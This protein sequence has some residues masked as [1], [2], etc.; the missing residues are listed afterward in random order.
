MCLTLQDWANI[1]V[2]V[3]AVF[4]VFALFIAIKQIFEAK[5]LRKIQMIRELIN[6]IGDEEIKKIRNWVIYDMPEPNQE[7]PLRGLTLKDIDNA[8]KL[9]VAYDRICFMI[10]ESKYDIFKKFHKDDVKIIWD[11]LENLIKYTQKKRVPKR[12]EY[13]K[14][15]EFYMNNIYK[16][17]NA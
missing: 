7:D 6:E 12:P 1:A 9:A 16:K 8:R 14:S 13:C 11:K 5:K 3:Q 4:V 17:T 15:F 10:I 2:F